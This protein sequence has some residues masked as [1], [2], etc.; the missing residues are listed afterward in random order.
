MVMNESMMKHIDDVMSHCIH[1]GMCL[2]VCP[3]YALT[4]QEQSSPRGRIRL[5]RSV[6]ENKIDLS[7]SFVDEMYFCLDCQACQ[8]ACPAGVQYGV[9]VEDARRLIAEKKYDPIT[10]RFVKSI[11]LR[12]ILASKFRTRLA[13]KILRW[14]QRSGLQEA[15]D[16]SDILSVFSDRLHDKHAMLPKIGEKFF[17]DGV[18]EVISPQG[19]PRGRV[20]FLF[21]C[22]MNVALPEVHRD[23]VDVL[24]ANGFEVIIPKQQVCCGSLHGHNGDIVMAKR[25]ARE[26][27]DVFQ[28]YA[29]D[30][31]IVDSAGCGAFLKEYGTLLVND[32]IYASKAEALSKKTKDITE[33]LVQPCEGLKPSQGLQGLRVTYHEACH[34]VHTQRVSQQPRQIIQSIPGIEFVELPEATWCCGSAGIYNVVR[35]DDSMKLLERK[36]NNLAS[37]NADI[38]LTANPGCHLQLQYGIRKFGVS[39][40]LGRH[41]AK[42]QMEVM[43]P[44]SLLNRTYKV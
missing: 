20:A 19:K 18:A 4:Y 27:I 2:P 10:L 25:V 11:F 43:H 31:L 35:F 26:N 6:H 16:R 23:T 34:L 13:A 3:T 22:I 5:I 36:I 41:G 14:Y 9:L 30:A 8:T 44:V 1:C 38:V 42:R 12:G 21:G 15:V 37:T 33:F 40:R 24:L 29:F 7:D 32:P 28:Q 17:D 39:E